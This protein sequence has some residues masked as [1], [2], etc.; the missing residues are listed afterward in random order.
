MVENHCLVGHTHTS[1]YMSRRREQEEALVHVVAASLW[2]LLCLMMAGG[3]HKKRL[4]T[5]EVV[6]LSYEV[7]K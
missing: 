3:G 7:K 1:Q 6:N 4:D 5:Q 2:Q